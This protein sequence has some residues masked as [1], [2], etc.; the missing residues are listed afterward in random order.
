MAEPPKLLYSDMVKKA[1][2]PHESDIEFVADP[3]SPQLE[4]DDEEYLERI[5]KSTRISPGSSDVS[6]IEDSDSG[7]DSDMPDPAMSVPEM[8]AKE[9]VLEVNLTLLSF[10]IIIGISGMSGFFLGGIYS[11]VLTSN[12]STTTSPALYP[13]ALP[14]SAYIL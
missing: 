13:G 3:D 12:I 4:Y 2:A 11:A 9:V 1:P 10:S 14:V 6:D 8:N 5:L 7:S